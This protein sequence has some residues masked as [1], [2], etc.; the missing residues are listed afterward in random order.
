ML[1][2]RFSSFFLLILSIEAS[3][4]SVSV[5]TYNLENLFDD[6]H[7]QG[8]LDF[9]FLP[10]RL[11]TTAKIKSYCQSQKSNKRRNQCFDLDWT[12]KQIDLKL[13]R[14]SQA[15]LSSTKD[16]KGP[17]IVVLQEIEN[18]AMLETLNQ[19][20]LQAADYRTSILLEG[21]DPRGID[22][23]VLS[24]FPE[25]SAAILHNIP[26]R[27]LKKNKLRKSRGI[28]EA[29]LLG[30]KKTSVIVFA[31]HFPAPYHPTSLRQQAIKFLDQL[32]GKKTK[33]EIIIAA[34]DFNISLEEE[35]NYR[36]Y[37]EGLSQNWWVSHL[38]GCQMCRGTYY[39]EPKKEWSFLDAILL[40]KT[41]LKRKNQWKIDPSSVKLV[42]HLPFQIDKDRRPLSFSEKS[43][44]SD[45]FPLFLELSTHQK[46]LK[47]RQSSQKAKFF[48]K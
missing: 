15:I 27:S 13:K 46:S 5:M 32:A 35:K 37:A 39:Y 26:F 11:K 21:E 7:E 2:L 17:D 1:K 8:K 47:K 36:L 38:V 29:S 9:T 42:D 31:L 14:I 25:K 43:G 10:K 41:Q 40:F 18:K 48:D 34:G 16:G 45:H 22:V 24:R 30:P 6:R 23:A 44:V 33:E 20:Y 12:A 3:A 28:L 4:A 19:K